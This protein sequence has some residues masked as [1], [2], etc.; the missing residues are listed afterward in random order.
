MQPVEG[1]NI[2]ESEANVEQGVLEAS[3]VNVVYEM[4]NMIAISRAYESNQ[5]V[6]KTVD[7]MIDRAVNQV[8][9]V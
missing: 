7:T 4:V 9:K 8:G 6:L 1:A 3:N 5:K 2:I